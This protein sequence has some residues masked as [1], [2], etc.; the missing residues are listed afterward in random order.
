V[1][2][3]LACDEAT[4]SRGNLLDSPLL[5][6]PDASARGNIPGFG[7]PAAPGE[8]GTLGP[9]RIIKPLGEGGMGTVYV[10]IDTRLDRRLA[11]KVMLPQFAADPAARER[12]LREARAAAQ[13]AHDNVITVY[14]AD[15]RDGVPYIAM[16]LLDGCTLDELLRETGAPPPLPEILG[17]AAQAADGLAAAH[18]IGLVHRDV[19]PSNLWLQAPGG[20]VK[21]LDFGLAKPLDARVAVTLTGAVIGT[22]AYMSPEQARGERLDH[23]TD[24]FSLGAVLYRLCGARLP[25]EGP[26]TMSVLMALGTEDPPPLR[27]LNP[28][29]PE[30]LAALIHQMLAKKREARPSSVAEVATRLRAIAKGVPLV[31]AA[32]RKARPSRRQLAAA[33]AAVL[34]V[35]CGGGAIVITR[36][37]RSR[38]VTT[39]TKKTTV[40]PTS[41]SSSA[42][43]TPSL[44]LDA[45]RDAAA[46]VISLGGT[47]RINGGGGDITKGT[48]LPDDRF[49]I[50]GVTLR[51]NKA[52]T[53]AALSHLRS[54]AELTYLN[55]NGTA[56]SDT[57][58]AH[59]ADCRK[60][61]ELWLRE[62]RTITG[63][64]FAHLEK[65]QALHD[66][67]LG[68]TGVDNAALEHVVKLKGLSRLFVQ[69]TKVDDDG[70]PRLRELPA[71]THIDLFATPV[72]DAGVPHLL[73]CR[74][75]TVLHLGAT[76]VGDDGVAQLKDFPALTDLTLIYTPITDAA[77]E[78]L[79]ECRALTALKVGNTSLTNRGV[80]H[81]RTLTRLTLLAFENTAVTDEGVA[82]LTGLR[83]LESLNLHDTGVTDAA[84]DHLATLKGL[85]LL[86]VRKTRMTSRG[87]AKFHAAVPGC[88]IQHDGGTIE[89][90]GPAAG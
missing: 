73:K 61:Q 27:E 23:R 8:V 30:P 78:H 41:A 59:L 45:D 70:L 20:R 39:T 56:I 71:L 74:G 82:Q 11:L 69:A 10:A 52:V 90:T 1:E 51:D 5:R 47:V 42:T 64:G 31:A 6:R 21:V 2:R 46:W 32:R 49:A 7:L 75:L 87:L 33:A 66:L 53:D 84:L 38:S 43:M 50:T 3:L 40:A 25:F 37:G 18:A 89:P 28:D 16:Q 63:D 86:D 34:L 54:A 29:V 9:Y 19:K 60:L 88:S 44:A 4:S 65:L 72:T 67:H 12:F 24:L 17:I 77:L 62:N 22:P 36:K 80:S 57:G 85:T 68:G 48:D 83:Q 79:K 58:L 26:T 13:V 14:E 81:L 55:L 76:R 35:A 15:E